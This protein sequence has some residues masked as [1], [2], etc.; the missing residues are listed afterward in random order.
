LDPIKD[1]AAN[2]PTFSKAIHY[3]LQDGAYFKT[4]IHSGDT[5]IN[6]NADMIA[7]INETFGPAGT[8][9][10]NIGPRKIDWTIEEYKPGNV[11]KIAKQT[12]VNFTGRFLKQEPSRKYDISDTRLGPTGLP[13]ITNGTITIPAGAGVGRNAHWKFYKNYTEPQ[14]TPL[15]GGGAA[16]FAVFKANF[17]NLI[18]TIYSEDATC[19]SSPRDPGGTHRGIYWYFLTNIDDKNND[20][21]SRDTAYYWDTN[22]KEGQAWNNKDDAAANEADSNKNAAFPDGRYILTITAQGYGDAADVATRKDTVSVNNFNE[23]YIV[24]MP[25]AKR[26]ILFV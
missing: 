26:R 11:A 12:P 8:G 13:V 22:G 4:T 14:V 16:I 15:Q 18:N 23:Q 20:I 10:Y 2:K 1:E 24:A 3:K 17:G 21:E 19:K 5:V 9:D 25:A 7:C 6:G